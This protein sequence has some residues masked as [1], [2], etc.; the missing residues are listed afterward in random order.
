MTRVRRRKR[1]GPNGSQT[2]KEKVQRQVAILR[3][4]NSRSRA[5]AFSTTQQPVVHKTLVINGLKV[6]F[7]PWL[8]VLSVTPYKSTE[9][10]QGTATGADLV[11]LMEHAFTTYA[12]KK[13]QEY[14]LCPRCDA[15]FSVGA[16]S[17]VHCKK[18]S[19]QICVECRVEIVTHF[20]PTPV[21]STA[22]SV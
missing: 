2:L 10:N 22:G 14:G 4:N 11:E 13:P 15:I 12:L 6:T 21:A 17:I 3:F 19:V 1:E 7:G 5:N 16:R 18:C 9:N 20:C 8:E